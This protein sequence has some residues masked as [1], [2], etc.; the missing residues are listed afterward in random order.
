MNARAIRRA[1]WFAVFL[2]AGAAWPDSAR[3]QTRGEE[4]CVVPRESSGLIRGDRVPAGCVMI[5]RPAREPAPRPA[6]VSGH[7]VVLVPV[8][9][10]STL[11]LPDPPFVGV[12]PGPAAVTGADSLPRVRSGPFGPIERP[13]GPVTQPFRPA[14]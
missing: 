6:I 12:P 10:R 13:F 3:A 14:P 9:V 5:E 1:T 8:L 7:T 2:G 4:E 11:F